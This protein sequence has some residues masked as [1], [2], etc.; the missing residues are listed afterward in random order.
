MSSYGWLDD[1]SSDAAALGHK[2]SLGNM[3]MLGFK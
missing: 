3:W 2:E 1:I